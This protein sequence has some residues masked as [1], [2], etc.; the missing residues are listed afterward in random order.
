MNTQNTIV[1]IPCL[2]TYEFITLNQIIRFEGYHNNTR[3]YLESG[4]MLIS[5]ESIG[6]YKKVLE[7]KE[8]FCCHKSHVINTNHIERYSKD[9]FVEMKDKST[10][11]VS[12]RKK[13]EFARSILNNYNLCMNPQ[14][15]ESKVGASH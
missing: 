4:K 5:S 12:R 13:D 7:D 9:G 15:V 10:I 14:R 6:V 1:A 8:F 3:I 2:R 11:P